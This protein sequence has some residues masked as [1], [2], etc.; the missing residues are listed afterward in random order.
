MIND[1]KLIISFTQLKDLNVLNK[2]IKCLLEHI[3]Q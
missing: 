1:V 2:K 3:R